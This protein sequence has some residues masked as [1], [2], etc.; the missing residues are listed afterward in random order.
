MG[1]ADLRERAQ[2]DH[3][4]RRGSAFLASSS[5]PSDS[6]M[7]QQ[8]LRYAPRLV[9][10]A[11][12]VI[13]SRARFERCRNMITLMLQTISQLER[14]RAAAGTE[15][16]RPRIAPNEHHSRVRQGRELRLLLKK[17]AA[18]KVRSSSPISYLELVCP[19]CQ[20]RHCKY[21]V[22]RGCWDKRQIKNVKRSLLYGKVIVLDGKKNRD[23]LCRGS[24]RVM[25]GLP[26]SGSGRPKYFP[27]QGQ[28]TRP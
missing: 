12:G 19:S 5:I 11:K 24:S 20:R 3:S 16:A 7:D 9:S 8:F 27:R 21:R 10:F 18:K 13:C 28:R 26:V 6:P 14:K 4:Y 22:A 23:R 2:L 15:K 1:V 17:G 25:H